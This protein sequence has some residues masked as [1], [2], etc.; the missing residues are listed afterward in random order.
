[1]EAA[2]ETAAVLR[3]SA[4]LRT[5]IYCSV[6]VT[7]ARVFGGEGEE[8]DEEGGEGVKSMLSIRDAMES[9]EEHLASLQVPI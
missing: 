6:D 3:R 5:K 7:C 9:L 4:D 1:M 8:E 2:V